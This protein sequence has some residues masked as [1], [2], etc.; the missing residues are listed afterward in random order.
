MLMTV[1]AVLACVDGLAGPPIAR[2]ADQLVGRV[3]PPAAGDDV[4]DVRAWR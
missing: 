2:G 1:A 4:R 3:G